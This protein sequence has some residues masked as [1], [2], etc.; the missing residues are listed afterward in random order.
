MYW[1]Q[2][3]YPAY[4]EAHQ[5]MFENGDVENGKPTGEKVQGLVIMEPVKKE[6][7]EVMS[8]NDM[9]RRCCEVLLDLMQ[10]S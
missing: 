9:V 7:E 5:E 4:V 8:M 6:E 2:I 1:E 3:V 10:G